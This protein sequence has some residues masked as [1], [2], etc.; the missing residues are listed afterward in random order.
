MLREK[1]ELENQLEQEEEYIVNEL[2]KKLSKLQAEKHELELRLLEERESHETLRRTQSQL[3]KAQ[4]QNQDLQKELAGVRS[5]NF[6]LTQKIAKEHQQLLTISTAKAQLEHGLEMD[7]ERAFNTELSRQPN[8]GRHRTRS[9][10]L[11]VNEGSVASEHEN[12]SSK[13][14]RLPLVKSNSG[15]SGLNSSSSLST[16]SPSS[17]SP[18]SQSPPTSPRNSM[19]SRMSGSS[20]TMG[21]GHTRS[22]RLS[23]AANA[24]LMH[25]YPSTPRSSGMILKQGW[26]RSTP[27]SKVPITDPELDPEPATDLY[28]I[29]SDDSTLSA[30]MNELHSS[31]GSSSLF[32]INLDTVMRRQLDPETGELVLETKDNIYNLHPQSED[33]KE[34]FDLLQQLDPLASGSSTPSH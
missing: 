31:D 4:Q 6:G 10:S 17:S 30:Y 13:L 28:F 15:S 14:P 20:P 3:S 5:E 21:T 19:D 29:L 16:D 18:T 12:D 11:P 27:H 22:R 34:W 24:S 7:D 26:M 33:T 32:C 23:I 2:Q 9:Q 8:G 25:H 1:I